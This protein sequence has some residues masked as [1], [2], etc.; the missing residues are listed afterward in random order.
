MSVAD[1]MSHSR[2]GSPGAAASPSSAVTRAGRNT[3]LRAGSQALSALINVGAMVLLGNHLSA[4]GYGQYAFY[5]AL[6][7][8]LA[9]VADLGAG[10][11]VT[12]EAARDTGR[13]SQLLGDALVLRAGMAVVLLLGAGFVSAVT[14]SPSDAVLLMLVTAAAVLDFGQDVSIWMLRAAERL[15]LEAVLLLVS[16]TAW[17]LGIALGV[18]LGATLPVLLAMA[19]GAF[20]LR[21]WAGAMML[22]RLGLQPSLS[23]APARLAQLVAEGWPVAASLLLVVLYGRVGVFVLKALAGDADVAN[24]NVAYMLSQPFGFLGSAL[25]MAVFPAF[26]RL[27]ADASA[28]LGGPLRSAYK[29][30]LLVS[31]P[32]AAGLFTLADRAV[33][34]LFRESAGYGAASAA[35]AVLSL[36]LPFVFF[37]LQARY[38]LAAVGR[39]RTYLWGVTTGLLVNV[40]GCLVTVPR[41]GVAGAAWTF[42]VAEVLVFA[43]CHG[44]LAGHVSF[45][46]LARQSLRPLAAA[47]VMAAW[48]WALRTAP[49]PLAIVA[50]AI[51]Y[52]LTL[53]L[54]RA[55]TRAEWDVIRE[56]WASFRFG[57]SGRAGRTA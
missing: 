23:V 1:A 27:G 51:A 37:N 53:V 28:D 52:G 7:P 10:V 25:A 40:L 54:V 45:G 29:Y 31:L 13:A 56:V 38:L 21:T 46:S 26:A 22:S 48:V 24:F 17:I 33:P 16:Q 19:V 55:L 15:D 18:A 35:L 41:F 14:L 32:L 6:I 11:V 9:S 36:A 44:A 3:A 57:R 2:P 8:L 42:V 43:A 39:Q 50:G 5:Y 34:L 4:A 12:R 47:L 49:L 30:Q 20:L